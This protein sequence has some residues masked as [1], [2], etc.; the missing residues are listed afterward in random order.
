MFDDACPDYSLFLKYSSWKDAT[1]R[2]AELTYLFLIIF[3]LHICIVGSSADR[4]NCVVKLFLEIEDN[5]QR[6]ANMEETIQKV[7]KKFINYVEDND[8]VL[9]VEADYL[10]ECIILGLDFLTH[11]DIQ[12]AIDFGK[13]HIG[14]ANVEKEIISER[15]FDDALIPPRLPISNNPVVLDEVQIKEESQDE[16]V[17]EL[18]S[19]DEEG[20]VMRIMEMDEEM[21]IWMKSGMYIPPNTSTF[22]QA[23][24]WPQK[25]WTKR[26]I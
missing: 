6:I 18:E 15:L 7:A 10:N 16:E 9:D 11:P 25:D 13:G 12:A 2:W 20:Q 22:V 17:P 26:P 23:V 19:D 1:Q 5:R 14:L 3:V 24:V 8:Q 21:F 4:R